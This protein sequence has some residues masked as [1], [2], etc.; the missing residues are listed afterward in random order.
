MT[1]KAKKPTRRTPARKHGAK[2]GTG[3]KSTP[4]GFVEPMERKYVAVVLK[5]DDERTRSTYGTIEQA[6]AHVSGKIG[7][8]ARTQGGKK[9]QFAICEVIEIVEAVSPTI[10]RRKPAKGDGS[11][12][13]MFAPIFNCRSF[14][15][16]PIDPRIP[17][18]Y[19]K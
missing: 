4:Q 6:Y 2:A 19:Q 14:F 10:M 17:E 18:G 15:D 3:W 16:A 8:I 13:V 7:E 12:S 5:A 11:P 1:K 9:L